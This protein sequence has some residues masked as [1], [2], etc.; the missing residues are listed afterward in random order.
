MAELNKLLQEEV[1]QLSRVWVDYGLIEALNKRLRQGYYTDIF[2]EDL[3][4]LMVSEGEG[5]DVSSLE[6]VLQLEK[7]FH[8]NVVL[9]E[10]T[11]DLWNE[12]ITDMINVEAIMFLSTYLWRYH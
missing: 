10:K 8:L 6:L 5:V 9:F 11:L 7:R 12:A 4:L 1:V 2:N 3:Q